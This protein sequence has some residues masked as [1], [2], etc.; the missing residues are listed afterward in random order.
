MW[1]AKVRHFGPRINEQKRI[2]AKIRDLMV[3]VESADACTNWYSL[4]GTNRL[5]TNALLHATMCAHIG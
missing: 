1:S 5:L 4:A 2:A 3:K